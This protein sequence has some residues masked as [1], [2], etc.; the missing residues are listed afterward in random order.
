MSLL[1]ST[2]VGAGG[3][4]P[5]APRVE[6]P[7]RRVVVYNTFARCLDCYRQTGKVCGKFNFPCF[8]R[9][10]CRRLETSSPQRQEADVEEV[11]LHPEAEPLGWR[12]EAE[13]VG[14]G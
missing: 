14:I 2:F 13:P 3:A 10:E 5:Q 11:H 8:R 7:H 12:P 6:G 1:L 9:Q 4:S